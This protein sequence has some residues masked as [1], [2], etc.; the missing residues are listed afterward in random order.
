MITEMHSVIIDNHKTDNQYN[1]NN[2]QN[3]NEASTTVEERWDK[4]NKANAYAHLMT[5]HKKTATIEHF[6]G[7]MQW[8]ITKFVNEA[9][10]DEQKK[11][12]KGI[13]S[14]AKNVTTIVHIR[15]GRKL[16]NYMM[17]YKWSISPLEQKL[18]LRKTKITKY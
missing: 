14:N 10:K 1:K 13:S 16:L 8:D 2:T 4:G 5:S 7:F 15:F 9:I 12:Q 6:D 18:L 3:S 17:E 11:I